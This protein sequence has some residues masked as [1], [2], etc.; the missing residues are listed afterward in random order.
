MIRLHSVISLLFLVYFSLGE[1]E[2]PPPL[3]RLRVFHFVLNDLTQTRRSANYLMAQPRVIT[4]L[5]FVYAR[6]RQLL[7][8]TQEFFCEVRG[9]CQ[10]SVVVKEPPDFRGQVEIGQM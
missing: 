5:V 2:S 10:D 3:D 7:I 1:A 8:L 4:S 6:V 9:S